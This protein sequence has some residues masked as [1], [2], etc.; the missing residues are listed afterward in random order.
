MVEPVLRDI[1]YRDGNTLDSAADLRQTATAA[2]QL[3]IDALSWLEG[4]LIIAA[5][6][7][8]LV[9]GFSMIIA[10]GDSEKISKQKTVFLW[11]GVGV[12]VMLLNKVVIQEVIYPY[13]LGDDFF[14]TYAPSPTTGITEIIAVIKYILYFLALIAFLVF[15]YGG[16]MM[17]LSFGDEERVG[18]GKK[19]LFGAAIG[20][21][22]ILISYALVSTFITLKV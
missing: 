22:V 18:N 8:I 1:I 12:I 3:I 9:S 11:V 17:I 20:I 10:L 4:L 19:A 2:S 21:I 5:I 16:A 6:G 14:V 7:Y 13:V 15:L